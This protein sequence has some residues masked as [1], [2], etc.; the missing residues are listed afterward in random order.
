LLFHFPAIGGE[1]QMDSL[2]TELKVLV[3]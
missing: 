2:V 1:K 3:P